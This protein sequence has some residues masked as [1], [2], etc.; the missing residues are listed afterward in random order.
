MSYDWQRIIIRMLA[1]GVLLSGS[2][3]AVAA[4]WVVVTAE[5]TSYKAGAILD[6]KTPV[7]LGE[8][9]HLTLLAED[10]KTLKLTGPYGGVPES[11]G[12][13][14]AKTNNLTAIASLLQGHRQSTSTLGVMRGFEG[15]DASPDPIEVD[16]SGEHCLISDPVVLL[17]DKIAKSEEVTLVD[18]QGSTLAIFTWPARQAEL[19]VPARY[20][21]DGK[22]YRLQR[23]D[24]PI[25]LLVH[26]AAETPTNP[27]SLAAWM[28]KQGCEA[29]AMR[30]LGKL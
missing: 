20:F 2:S 15:D 25:S 18:E 23:G 6:D 8:G 29:Q 14:G 27:A 9:A 17:R 13:K 4:Q 1:G 3:L 22:R 28:I 21:E 12:D 5:G 7:K 26:K 30:V 24:K 19:P 16:N 10:G 11:G